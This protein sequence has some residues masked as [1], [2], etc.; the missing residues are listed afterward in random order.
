LQAK[1][2][3]YLFFRLWWRKNIEGQSFVKNGDLNV[4]TKQG[5]ER[6]ADSISILTGVFDREGQKRKEFFD[7]IDR[8]FRMCVRKEG[9]KEFENILMKQLRFKILYSLL[10]RRV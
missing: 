4:I 1:N 7:G 9:E 8:I 5:Y 3:L 2:T 10:G 6:N